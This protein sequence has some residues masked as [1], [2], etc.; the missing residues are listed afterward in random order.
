MARNVTHVKINQP[1]KGIDIWLFFSR[2]FYA[3]L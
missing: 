2:A 1:Q 3:L